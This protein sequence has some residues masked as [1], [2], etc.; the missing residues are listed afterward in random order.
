VLFD[1]SIVRVQCVSCNVFRRGNYPI[2]TTKLIKENGMD[3]WEKKLADACKVVKHTRADLEE[4][5]SEYQEKLRAL[6]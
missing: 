3:W 5:I 6:V 1:D 4:M 2:F